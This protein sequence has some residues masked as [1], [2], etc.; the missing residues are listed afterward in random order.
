MADLN[1]HH[2]HE[3][4]HESHHMRSGKRNRRFGLAELPIGVVFGLSSVV[5][6]GL[7]NLVD[8]RVH[9]LRHIAEFSPNKKERR[10]ARLKASAWLG[11]VG[12]AG[13]TFE[14]LTNIHGASSRTV[15]ILGTAVFGAET[16]MN[17]RSFNDTRR[18]SVNNSTSTLESKL[19]NG[20]DAIVST[21][22]T[23]SLGAATI[24]NSN[25]ELIDAV[26]NYAH[27][28]LVSTLI[29]LTLFGQNQEY[30]TDAR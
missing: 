12:I 24:T 26:V 22:S 30:D 1:D 20:G 11:A 10:N 21:L 23:I 19:H 3:H 4:E 15:G 14:R 7:H 25:I 18:S 9:D 5:L 8:G 29:G 17:S 6:A 27:L 28:G 13:F 2:Q 16:V